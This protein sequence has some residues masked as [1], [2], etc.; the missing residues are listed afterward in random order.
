MLDIIRNDYREIHVHMSSEC[1]L[2]RSKSR[3][4][5]ILFDSNVHLCNIL[6]N[7]AFSCILIH[8]HIYMYILHTNKQTHNLSTTQSNIPHHHHYH[9][10]P[11]YQHIKP[12]KSKKEKKEKKKKRTTHPEH[13]ILS[14]K[15]RRSSST[16]HQY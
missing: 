1:R 14:T 5:F 15:Q 13:R 3:R 9:P 4:L 11:T 6:H 16:Q 7:Y 8:T 10:H 12:T 2:Y